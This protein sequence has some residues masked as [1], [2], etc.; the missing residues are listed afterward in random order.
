MPSTS[1]VSPRI[2][3]IRK[4]IDSF[5]MERLQVELNEIAKKYSKLKQESQESRKQDERK[6]K[7]R[8]QEK[9]EKFQRKNWLSD[10]AQRVCQLQQV[11]HALKYAHP[12]AKGANC[13]FTVGQ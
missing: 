5:L 7:E 1:Q 3:V 10:A 2:E 4:V 11:T 13:F 12:D 6:L 9:R 8:E